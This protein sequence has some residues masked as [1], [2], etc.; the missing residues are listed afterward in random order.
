MVAHLCLLLTNVALEGS[1]GRSDAVLRAT[2]N[3]GGTLQASAHGSL[4]VLIAERQRTVAHALARAV[5]DSNSANI[6]ASVATEADALDVGAKLQPDVAIVDLDLSPNCALVA[7]L[8]ALCPDTRIIVLSDRDGDEGELMVKA[9]A[10]GAVGAMYKGDSFDQL[11]KAMQKSTRSTPVM[12]EEA[13]GL[14]LNSYLDAMS[15][16]RERDLATIQALAAAVEARDSGTGRH[17]RRVTDLACNCM[18]IIDSELAA[19]EELGFGFLL[20]DV[21]KIGIPDSVLKKP[22]PL[23]DR[24]WASMRQHPQIGVRIVDPIGFSPVATDVILC[25]H[26]RWDGS[27]YPHGLAGDE[28][29]ITARAFSVAD[30]YDAMTSDRPYRSAMPRGEAKSVIRLDRGHRFDPDVVDAFFQVVA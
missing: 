25:H 26:E 16:K 19:N 9:L 1:G 28:I 5:G 24:E 6:A 7:G 27:G 30:A 17:L 10:T 29:P 18:E 21:G 22:G 2:E 14:L 23:D 4:T 11:Y 13:A 20:H 3:R 8:H 12:A 15:D